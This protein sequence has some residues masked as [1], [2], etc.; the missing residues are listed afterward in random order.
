[1]SRHSVFASLYLLAG[2]VATTRKYRH[3]DRREENLPISDKTPFT[4]CWRIGD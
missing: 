2:V 4:T 3:T 1:M